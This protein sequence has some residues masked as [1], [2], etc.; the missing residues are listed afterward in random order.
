VNN[1]KNKNLEIAA[2][3]LTSALLA[4]KIGVDRIEFCADYGLGGITPEIEDF[5]MLRKAFSKP[6]YVMIRPRWGDF[7][8]S[9][10]EIVEMAKS[11]SEF[12]KLGADGFVFGALTADNQI[13]IE[14]NSRLILQTN[15]IPVSFHR[16]FDRT[17]NPFEAL[18]SVIQC[19]FQ[20]ILSSGR[21]QC[22]LQGASLLGELQEQA[23]NR[24]SFIAGGGVRSDNL[25]SILSAFQTS[26]Y[27]SSGI[28]D[29]SHLANE[30]EL[31]QLMKI[32]K[33]C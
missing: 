18:E 30:N 28:I 14:T 10:S 15:A 27:H 33:E 2:F 5:R 1:E 20:N 29:F 25:N 3:N 22:V 13:D 9:K 19:G 4:A 8:Y 26:F 21:Q 7:V 6:I 16:A 24:I 11:I 17:V 32:L 31:I 12:G 23:A